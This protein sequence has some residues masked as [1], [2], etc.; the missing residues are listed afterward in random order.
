MAH[1]HPVI[2][3]NAHLKIDPV[4]RAIT[5]EDAIKTIVQHDHNSER[6][7][8]ELPRLV[9]GH[10]MMECS[11]IEVH[12]INI[13]SAHKDVTSIGVYEVNDI[14][15][16]EA[17]ENNVEFTWLISQN[18][19]QYV[20]TLNFL[21]KFICL[22]GTNIDYIWHTTIF[23]KVTIAAGMNNGEVI[24]QEYPDILEQWKA[25]V[26]ANAGGGMT[27]TEKS[28]MLTLF[29]NMLSQSD[30][31]DTVNT[32][33]SIWSG[34]GGGE[35]PDTPI[36]PDTP[37][38]YTVKYNLTNVTPSNSET[39]VTGGNSFTATLTADTDYTL[40]DVMVT[41]GG[42]DVTASVYTDGVIT[43]SNVT[44]NI[45]ITATA[46]DSSGA[47]AWEEG[48][49]YTF[50]IIENEYVSNT[51]GTFKPEQ[52]TLRTDYTPCLGVDLL[53]FSARE[54][55]TRQY[56]AFFDENKNF[57]TGF[58]IY[59]TNYVDVPDNAAYFVISYFPKVT[60]GEI[61]VA[62]IGKVTATWE[63][64][65]PYTLTPFIEN[66]YLNAGVIASY[67]GW[68][69]TEKLNCA[70][71]S[72]LILSTALSYSCFYDKLGNF[73]AGFGNVTEV[74]IPPG[75]VQFAISGS[76]SDMDSLVVT[77]HA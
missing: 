38:T 19:T 50:S 43:I 70:N 53:Y 64:G 3:A 65:V 49:P 8:F 58:Y 66:V 20:G 47:T 28:L 40:G 54:N 41:M 21:I 55:Q 57:I 68:K 27:S 44:G 45:V 29:K 52:G 73:V 35:E 34:S 26:L 10:D 14:K 76:N 32:L 5:I 6:L 56:N 63:D 67:D 23:Q 7:T 2:D 9:D 69:A 62:P 33:E 74:T 48:V 13:D 31:S 51:N 72:K 30:M 61:K 37:T 22:T 17:D 71:A 39:S 59:N 18:A 60:S 36:E 15:I 25:E 1:L 16:S 42:L 24:V 11:K 4:T 46:T 77:P 12:Y 75:A